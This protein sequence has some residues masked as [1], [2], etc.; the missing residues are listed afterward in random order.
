[1]PNTIKAKLVFDERS[2]L[3]A[4]RLHAWH[5]HRLW[6]LLRITL[7][8]G[9]IV[10]AGV[11]VMLEGLTPFPVLMLMVGTF[12]LLR[13]LIWKI[14]HARNLRQL[15]GYGQTVIYTIS[16][17]N[18]I[19]HGETKQATIPLNDLFEVVPLKQGL[20]LYHNKKSYTWLPREAFDSEQNFK[21]ASAW[22]R[23]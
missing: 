1:M 6:L 13:P 22:L 4:F 12:A 14:M 23:R 21:Q 8:I 3:G 9:C 11:F 20:L 5:R 17:E 7:S 2:H 16:P 19:I 18:I 10:G 15:P